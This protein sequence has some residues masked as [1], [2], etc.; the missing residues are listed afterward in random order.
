M[1]KRA[2]RNCPREKDSMAIY[3][4]YYIITMKFNIGDRVRLKREVLVD[5]A[6]K[7]LKLTSKDEFVVSEI[8][9]GLIWHVEDGVKIFRSEWRLELVE[10]EFSLGQIVEVSGDWEEWE[11]ST[12]VKTA[13]DNWK[14]KYITVSACRWDCPETDLVYFT[15]R[16]YI[17]KIKDKLKRKEIAEK[18]G[19][20]EDFIIE[21]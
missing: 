18:F 5:M 13:T 15:N 1:D 20:N 21:D 6:K 3:F 19:V 4:I 12:Y 10:E 14:N 7:C 17:R 11:K 16:K 8:E 2:I 9:W